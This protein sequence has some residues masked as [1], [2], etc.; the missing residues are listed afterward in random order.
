MIEGCL[1]S[2][3]LRTIFISFHLN[4]SVVSGRVTGCGDWGTHSDLMREALAA[5][6]FRWTS[7]TANFL[8]PSLNAKWS[9]D[10]L[11]RFGLTSQTLPQFPLPICAPAGE[12]AY[13][14]MVDLDATSST[15]SSSSETVVSEIEKTS[16][17]SGCTGLAFVGEFVLE[18]DDESIVRW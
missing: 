17:F 16:E 3:K 1:S 8:P 6:F 7:L 12:L 5:V 18:D 13:S 2:L 4:S 15:K 14:L 11:E 9:L 10:G